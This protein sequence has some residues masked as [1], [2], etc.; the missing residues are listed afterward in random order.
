[1]FGFSSWRVRRTEEIRCV[2]EQ[3]EHVKNIAIMEA[4]M[5]VMKI[6][7]AEFDKNHSETQTKAKPETKP[8]VEP[9][10]FPKVLS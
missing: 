3:Q 9:A 5:A 10:L 8:R 1:M 7:L 6:T 2:L 4:R